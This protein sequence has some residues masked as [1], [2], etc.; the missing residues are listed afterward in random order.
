MNQQLRILA[1]A[2]QL[3]R[4]TSYELAA[5]TG[6]S[7]NTVRSVL[8]RHAQL[9][10]VDTVAGGQGSRG[11]PT[12]RYAVV[13]AEALRAQLGDVRDSLEWTPMPRLETTDVER[14]AARIEVAEG[15]LRR[16]LATPSDEDRR[17]LA[18]VAVEVAE[19]SL[20]AG[21]PVEL[22]PRAHWVKAGGELA[23]LVDTSPTQM[24]G[25]LGSIATSIA[26]VVAH[27]DAGALVLLQTLMRVTRQ[28]R[29][30]PPV[31]L[32]VHGDVEPECILTGNVKTLWRQ[33]ALT[34]NGGLLWSPAWSAPLADHDALAGVVLRVDAGHGD[35]GASLSQLRKWTPKI[36]TGE[37]DPE[38]IERA[39]KEGA[40]FLPSS[41]EDL[42]ASAVEGIDAAL[43]Q[44]I[45][46]LEADESPALAAMIT[47][48]QHAG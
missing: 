3:E 41:S 4:F 38:V 7:S 16:A 26:A 5:A 35:I 10:A 42:G 2:A 30:A 31:G 44:R 8:R 9:F 17:T 18:S 40:M 12:N 37:P 13:D 39:T 43:D 45:A 48:S 33:R 11:R 1:A 20:Q 32:I 23:G 15:S 46:G 6:T 25:T 14:Q 36:V 22:Q 47:Y 21:L 24:Q 19:A 27:S 34:R 29:Q 28:L